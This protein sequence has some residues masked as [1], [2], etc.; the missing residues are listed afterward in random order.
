[1]NE[2]VRRLS[3]FLGILGVACWT[4]ASLGLIF[5]GLWSEAAVWEWL[6]GILLIIA[7]FF[8]VVFVPWGLVRGIAWVIEGFKNKN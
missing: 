2:G 6:L 1:M 3:F 7:E 4:V 5:S 8:C